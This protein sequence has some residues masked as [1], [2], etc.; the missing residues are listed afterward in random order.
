MRQIVVAVID[1]AVVGLLVLALFFP[2]I[3][4]EVYAGLA[5][6]LLAGATRLDSRSR[7]FLS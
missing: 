7:E 2:E 4:V 1:I 6:L 3:P 5:G